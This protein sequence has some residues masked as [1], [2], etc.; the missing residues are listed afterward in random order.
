MAR[1]MT[2]ILEHH[3]T[4]VLTSNYEEM[5]ADYTDD[6]ILITMSGV[7]IGKKAIG[8]ALQ[9]LMRDMP[10]MTP[11]DSPSNVLAIEG[12]TLL[13]RW[14]AKSARGRI[15]DAVDT[16]VVKGDK[17]WRHTTSFEIVPT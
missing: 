13:L 16:I 8:G 10:G 17:I 6:A 14:S 1:A 4:A 11:I 3:N 7:Y 12:D 2:D 5:V 9:Q 15:K